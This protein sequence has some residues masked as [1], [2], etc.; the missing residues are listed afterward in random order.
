MLQSQTPLPY[1]KVKCRLGI[2]L[3]TETIT[4]SALR[5]LPCTP[6]LSRRANQHPTDSSQHYNLCL[7]SSLPMSTSLHGSLACRIQ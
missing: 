6:E 3:N 1:L 2:M 5:C 4:P 7:E